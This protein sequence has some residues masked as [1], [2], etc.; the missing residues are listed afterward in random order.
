MSEEAGQIAETLITPGYIDRGVILLYDTRQLH[1]YVYQS[2]TIVREVIEHLG[3]GHFALD[4]PDCLFHFERGSPAQLG[5]FGVDQFA[6]LVD[7]V[8]PAVLFVSEE[9]LGHELVELVVEQD[10]GDLARVV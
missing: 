1:L 8:V 5:E 10:G 3:E 2:A 9:G 7:I 4:H 6:V